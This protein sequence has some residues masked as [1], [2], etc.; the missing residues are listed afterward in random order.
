MLIGFG[1]VKT[2]MSALAA[3][4]A[5]AVLAPSPGGADAPPT[6]R[7]LARL[8]AS[9]IQ[10]DT[11]GTGPQLPAISA[12]AWM[13]TD[14]TTGA[15]LAARNAHRPLPPASTL[16]TL[17]ALTV[18]PRL[19]EDRTHTV[20]PA[21]L[22]AVAPGSSTAGLVAG[23][24]YRVKDLWRAVFL[25]SGNDAVHVLARMNGGWDRTALEMEEVAVSLG[26]VDTDVISPDGFDAPG[27]LST[28][29]DLSVIAAAGLTDP[30]FARHAATARARFPAGGGRTTQITS[31][32]RLLTGAGGVT[33]YFGL[34]GVKNGYTSRA[35]NTLLAA[36]QRNGRTILVTVLN[37]TSGAPN[38]V[39][40]EARALLDWGFTAADTHTAIAHLSTG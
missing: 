40:E 17:F 18:M 8:H 38:A 16:K 28:A 3:C 1:G 27:Q 4:I 24:T 32:N 15:V 26:A 5:V 22:A 23:R 14:T 6:A 2:A 12:L 11:T 29:H 39:Y 37:P 31:T 36:A 13:V 19:D 25:R 10:V 7:D 21:D 33:P 34:I 30:S 20:T 9:G 35:G